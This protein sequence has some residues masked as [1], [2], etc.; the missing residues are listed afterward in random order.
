MKQVSVLAVLAALSAACGGGGEEHATAAAPAVTVTVASADLRDLGETIEVGGTVR[1][2]TVAVLTSRTVGQVREIGAR[3]GQ[4]VRAGTVLAV[5]DGRE[6]DANR[7][8]AE[9]LLAAAA[10][11]QSAAEADRAAADASL[12]LASATHARIAR[13]R[14]RKSATAQELDE[15]QAA[16]SAAEA[17]AKG[18][19]AAVAAATA[20]LTGARAAV[21]AA[22]VSA[23]YSR[24]V[25]P[26]HGT[27]TQRHVDEGA[28]AM[29]GTPVL[30]VEEDGAQ[31][32]EVRLDETR[33]ARVDWNQAPL[34]V[35]SAPDGRETTVEG[36]VVE[37]AVALDSAHTSVVK[38]ALPA[39]EALRTGMFARVS[40]RGGARK[41][42]AVPA[43]AVVQRGQLDAVFVVS[44]GKARY[45]VVET[46]RPAAGFV[47][48]RSGLAPGEQVVRAAPA[49]LVDGAPVI[50]SG[51][52]R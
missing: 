31:Q 11:G 10:Q 52:R 6:M 45:R 4:K 41:A 34:V 15:A 22:R 3:P 28:M 18:A 17:R 9:A 49:S 14:E 29:P 8:R 32:V 7:D 25:A 44:D 26:F 2:R 16:L 36:R 5:L 19:N 23:E 42:L 48:V 39:T 37:R 21:E 46:G 47:E 43:D 20:N 51:G 35:F 24:L 13:L 50:A 33:A 40:F 38:V 30:T 1:A 12:R 27:V